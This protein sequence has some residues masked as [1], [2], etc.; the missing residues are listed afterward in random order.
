MALSHNVL[1]YFISKTDRHAYLTADTE[2][3]QHE[4][5]ES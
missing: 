3:K 2:E 4:E 1:T 5:E